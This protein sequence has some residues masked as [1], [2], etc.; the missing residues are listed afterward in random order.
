MLSW[1][2]GFAGFNLETTDAL[3]GAGAWQM[4]RGPYTLSKGSFQAWTSRTNGANAFYRLRKP[5]L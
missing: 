5:L 2:S 1:G 3:S 4:L